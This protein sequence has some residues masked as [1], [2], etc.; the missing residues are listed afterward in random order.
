[1][2]ET[3]SGFRGSKSMGQREGLSGIGGCDVSVGVV[4]VGVVDVVVV[5]GGGCGGL[6]A[7]LS[8]GC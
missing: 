1:M 3:A 7:G 8:S 6:P 5:G 4:V 2:L